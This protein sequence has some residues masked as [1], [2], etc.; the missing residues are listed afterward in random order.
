MII[1]CIDLET[2]GLQADDGICELGWCD[3][4]VGDNGAGEIVEPPRSVLINPGKP[5]PPSASAVHHIVDADV[6][7]AATLE[8]AVRDITCD[9]AA[10]RGE[11]V[12]CAHNA[13][14]EQQFIKDETM[15]WICSYKVAVTLAPNAP[16]HKLQTLRYWAKLAVDPA[17]AN[18]PHRAAADAYI[19]AALVVRL[20]S[21]MTL[22]QMIEVSAKPVLLPRFTFGKHA[23][24]PLNVVPDSYLQW[25]I[26]NI[27]DDEDVLY[28]A[29]TNLAQRR[30][31]Q[32]SRSPV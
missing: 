22:E 21:K 5:I 15:R 32:R 19:C 4:V 18:P 12:L 29:K 23:M 1:R 26:G 25:V 3:V 27:D 11:V 9:E 17:L 16:E 2:L 20:L 8:D 31:A 13:R 7:G 14:F 28:T 6:A 24:Q 30:A 10:M